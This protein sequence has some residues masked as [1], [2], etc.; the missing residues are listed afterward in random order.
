MKPPSLHCEHK[1]KLAKDELKV[2]KAED[3]SIAAHP[4][5]S[6]KE[7]E[8]RTKELKENAKALGA[9]LERKDRHG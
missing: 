5:K 2:L 7:I 4:F 3:Y 6:K 9:G 1:S 8:A